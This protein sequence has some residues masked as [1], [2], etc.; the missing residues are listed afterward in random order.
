MMKILS[1]YFIVIIFLLSAFLKLFDFRSTVELFV[2]LLG[3]GYTIIRI[4]LA[5]LILLELTV[6][7]LVTADYLQ[8][9]IVYFL[10]AGLVTAFIIVNIFLLLTGTKNCGCFGADIVSTPALSIVKNI[11]LLSALIYV[12]RSNLNTNRK[13]NLVMSK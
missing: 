2:N 3:M 8:I 9:K 10:I 7:Y 13:N 4:L 12:R 5:L 6:A 11:L 1:K